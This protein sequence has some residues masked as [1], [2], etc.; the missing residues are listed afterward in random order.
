MTSEN[1]S[2]VEFETLHGPVRSLFEPT[3]KPGVEWINLIYLCRGVTQ[4]LVLSLFDNINF[5]FGFFSRTNIT[6]IN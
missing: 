5:K 3:T 1:S 2:E 6:M 4:K